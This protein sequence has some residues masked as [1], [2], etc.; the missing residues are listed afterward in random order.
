M[1]N[2][3][4][5][6]HFWSGGACRTAQ[7]KAAALPP[8]DADLLDVQVPGEPGIEVWCEHDEGRSENSWHLA[9]H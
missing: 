2:V 4:D 8:L 1:T 7:I 6:V 5:A 9:T 3:G